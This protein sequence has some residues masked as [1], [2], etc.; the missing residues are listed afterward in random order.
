MAG[1]IYNLFYMNQSNQNSK[2]PKYRKAYLIMSIIL[3]TLTVIMLVF[4]FLKPTFNKMVTSIVKSQ[5]HFQDNNV[6]VWGTFPGKNDII[7]VNNI[8]F[9]NHKEIDSSKCIKFEASHILIFSQPSSRTP[10]SILNSR[11]RT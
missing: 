9:F 1:V 7:I 11:C 10:R 6:D 4:L 2:P 3:G 5:A 8:T